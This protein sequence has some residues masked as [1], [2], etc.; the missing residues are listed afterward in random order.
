MARRTARIEAENLGALFCP[1]MGCGDHLKG[2]SGKGG[3]DMDL[4][5]S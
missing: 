4:K 1:W 3:E 2:L 5:I